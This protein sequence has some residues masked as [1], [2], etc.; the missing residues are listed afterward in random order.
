MCN[1]RW[2]VEGDFNVVRR[3]SEKFNSLSNTRS[4]REFDSL[5]GEL[6]LVNPNLNNARLTW[7]NCREYLICYRLDRFLFTNEWAVVYLCFKEEVEARVISD[8]S[9]VVL[10]TSTPRWGL[11]PFRFENTWL[12]HKHFSR[13]FEKWWKDVMVAGWEDISGW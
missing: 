13:D 10:D 4:M 9:L 7:S 8:H 11:R 3:M 1:D 2:C 5:I 6:D 12:E